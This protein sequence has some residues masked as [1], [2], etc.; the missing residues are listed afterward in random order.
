QEEDN[1]KASVTK[2]DQTA[3]LQVNKYLQLNNAQI[4]TEEELNNIKIQQKKQRSDDADKESS[5]ISVSEGFESL[6]KFI[7]FF[8]QQS[9]QHFKSDDLNVI[10]KY[11]SIMRCKNIESKKQSSIRNFFIPAKAN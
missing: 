3:L 10:Q 2:L 6:R 4:S 9:D 5:K 1:I 7:E 11:L 8:K